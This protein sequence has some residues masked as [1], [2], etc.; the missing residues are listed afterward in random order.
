MKTP[1]SV[2]AP[3]KTRG[4]FRRLSESSSADAQRASE[5]PELPEGHPLWELWDLLTEFYG[6]S[7]MSQYGEQPTWAWFGALQELS[8]ADYG[9]G[10]QTLKNRDN[11]F[12]PNPG[13][14]FALCRPELPEQRRNR[15]GALRRRIP[16]IP[17]PREQAL[18]EIA[19]IKSM[20][21][22]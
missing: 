15:E 5:Y 18:S 4:E 9:V 1:E 7:F 22:S 12:P 13:E 16:V 20:I 17:L 8:A 19:K 2:M 21:Q 3:V 10:F 11:P 14:F 6:S